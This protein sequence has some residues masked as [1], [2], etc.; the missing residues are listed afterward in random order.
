MRSI[1]KKIIHSTGFDIKRYQKQS[2]VFASSSRPVGEIDMLLEDLKQRGLKCK[3]ILDVGANLTEWSRMAKEIFPETAFYLIEPQLEMKSRLDKFV[4]DFP[5]SKY[6]LAGAGEN[7]GLFTL[8]IWDDLAGSSFLPPKDESKQR[9][10]KQR[11]IEIITID[12]LIEA[13]KIKIPEL[14]KMDIQGFELTALKGAKK[15]FGQTE[16]Y[17]LETSLFSFSDVPGMPV[18]SDV[19]SFMLERNYV[20]YDFPGFT[21]RPLDGALGQC[22]VCFVKRDGFLRKSND[23]G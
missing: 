8:T 4:Q 5:D 20:V 11:D 13:N 21:R 1:I 12:A 7:P 19:V 10:G 16:V 9:Q 17:I 2:E 23:W 6:F 18:F 15:T 22:D 3:S 14:I